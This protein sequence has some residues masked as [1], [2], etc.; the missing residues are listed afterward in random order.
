MRNS[1]SQ[2]PSAKEAS[3]LEHQLSAG[4]VVFLEVWVLEFLWMLDVGDWSF[5]VSVAE[6]LETRCHPEVATLHKLD[7]GLEFVFLFPRDPDLLVLQLA[8]HLEA[9]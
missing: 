1:K 3:N 8:L 4:C 9:L 5:G 2:H 7:D 6:I